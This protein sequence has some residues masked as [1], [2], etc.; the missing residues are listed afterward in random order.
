MVLHG[1]IQI[2][3]LEDRR[4]KTGKQLGCYNDKL[5]R[6]TGIAEAVQHPRFFI[7]GPAIGFVFVCFII[8]CVH[9][10]SRTL[11][12]QELVQLLL[13]HQAAWAVIH[14]HLRLIAVG[15]DFFGEVLCNVRTDLVDAFPIIHDRLH[16]DSLGEFSP[17]RIGQACGQH[18]KFPVHGFPVHTEIDRHR[19]KVQRQCSTV[20]NRIGETVLAHVTAPIL[21][22]AK[23]GKSVLVNAVDGSAG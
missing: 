9:H 15:T 11:C 3:N 10:N 18:I 13:I 8:I 4:I 2:H 7:L 23:G 5:Q 22:G 16:I 17:L 6:I 14:N 19:L 1:F 12:A 21:G 20:T